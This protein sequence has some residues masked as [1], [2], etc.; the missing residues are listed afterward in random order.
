M[1]RTT[2]VDRGAGPAAGAPRLWTCGWR[3][4]AGPRKPGYDARLRRSRS[5]GRR[6]CDVAGR[7]SR[8][9]AGA[10]PAGGIS[11]NPAPTGGLDKVVIES[12]A[13]GVPAAVQPTFLPV[14]GDDACC[15]ARTSPD[16]VADRLADVLGWDRRSGRRSRGWRPACGGRSTEGSSTGWLA[17]S[18][19]RPG[20][21]HL[22][23]NA[24]IP[25][26]KA[27]P[28]QIAQM[29]EAFAAAGADHADYLARRNPPDLDTGTSG[30]TGVERTFRAS[31]SGVDL[32]ACL[33]AAG[34]AGARGGPA[35]C[36]RSTCCSTAR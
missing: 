7:G 16:C 36:D 22:P 1:I 8:R 15:G 18:R 25:S 3:L 14:L 32:P 11:A 10:V 20:E 19:M 5:A 13:S 17:C 12:L 6:A 24:R 26:E 9:R 2:S 4:R 28:Y 31:A 29:C 23:G 27:H 33:A 34:A 21:A 30:R 35:C